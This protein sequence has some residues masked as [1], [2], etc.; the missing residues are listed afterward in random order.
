MSNLVPQKLAIYYGYPSGV[1]QTFTV[2]GAANVFKDYNQV[3]FGTGLE[4]ISHPDHQNTIDII[5][6]VDMTNTEVFGYIDAVLSL[7]T[8]QEKIDKWYSMGVSGIFMDQFGY[9]FGVSR[10]KQREILWSIHEKGDNTLKAFVNAWNPDDVFSSNIDAI[11]NPN[12]LTTRLGPNDFYLAESF[13]VMN[14][15]YDDNDI[16]AD[17]I[18]DWQNKAVKIVDYRTTYGTKL[19]AVT[20]WDSSV[21]DQNKMDY[22][23]YASILNTFNTFGFGEDNF[24]ASSGSLPMR[25]RKLFSGTQFVG[26]V[27][28]NGNIYYRYL[29]AGISINTNNHTVDTLIE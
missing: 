17:N 19:A 5:N 20:T 16:D 7:N 21:F 1:N 10:E 9:D 18:K 8:I 26:P 4:D 2:S 27:I 14:G 24:S 23:Y 22:A 29:N 6:H 15:Q 13:A 11:H 25:D 12:G 28:M 3:V